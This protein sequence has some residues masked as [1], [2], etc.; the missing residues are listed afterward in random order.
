MTLLN[1]VMIVKNGNPLLKNT[2][3]AIKPYIDR[4]TILDTGSTDGSQDCVK[5]VLSGVE[6]N[7]YEE[8]FVDFSTSRNRALELAGKS[9]KYNIML[10]DSYIIHGGEKLREI[11]STSNE[12]AYSIII[13]DE[14]KK[15]DSVR[16]TKSSAE[17]RYKYRVHEII[18]YKNPSQDLLGK[19]IYLEDCVIH[20]HTMR[21]TDRYPRDLKILLEEYKSKP[22]DA[23]IIFYIAQTYYTMTDYQRASI[24]YKKRVELNIKKINISHH[25]EVYYSLYTLGRIY[26]KLDDWEKAEIYFMKAYNLRPYRAEPIYHIAKYYFEQSNFDKAEKFLI[27]LIKL[28]IPSPNT[29]SFLIE[30][31]LYKYDIPYLLIETYFR[32]GET[33]FAIELAK[34]LLGEFPDDPK[35]KN[36]I[37]TQETTPIVV[38]KYNKPTVVINTGFFKNKWCPDNYTQ[39]GVSGSEIMAMNIA[40]TLCKYDINVFV[41]S[42]CEGLEGIYDNVQ[43]FDISKYDDFIKK[44]YINYLIVS[45]F[46]QFLRYFDNIENVYFW[47]HDILPFENSFQTHKTKFKKII[48]LSEWHKDFFYNEYKFP[49]ERISIIGNAIDTTRFSID[50]IEKVAYRF[51]YSSSSE[52]GFKH[53]LK[54]FSK[55]HDRYPTA[56][57]HAFLENDHGFINV[58][59]FIKINKRV[60]QAQLAIEMMKSDVWLYPTDFDETYCITALEAQAAKCLCVCINRAALKTIVGSRGVMVDG[61]PSKD[62]VQDKLLEELFKVLDDPERKKKLIQAG[63]EWAQRQ[64]FNFIVKEWINLFKMI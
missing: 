20:L 57:L 58:P 28:D 39:V 45:R 43:Y 41:F 31:R 7:L 62:S 52:R 2:L 13:T 54:M 10:D 47:L 50:S 19:D 46:P 34:K 4:W 61:D 25:S 42:A 17:L 3:I 23:R 35:L 36:I 24:Y 9:C 56:E 40:K 11:L 21:S 8:P 48:C 55:I 44:T 49:K 37:S 15:Y 1:L 29:D 27:Q 18:D 51:I 38:K 63:Y 60:S 5:E 14:N 6:G 22:K 12:N 64:D 53:L 32:K 59:D 16:I 33:K 30:Y 26:K